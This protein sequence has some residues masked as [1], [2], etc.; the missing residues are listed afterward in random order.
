MTEE[1][2][3]YG[4]ARENALD[5]AVRTITSGAD[6]DAILAVAARYAAFMRDTSPITALSGSGG[7][8]GA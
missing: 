2:R 3:G 1:E 4:I 8:D 7:S 5:Y 6:A